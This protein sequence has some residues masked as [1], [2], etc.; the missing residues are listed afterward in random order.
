MDPIKESLEKYNS[1]HKILH[2]TIAVLV[3]GLLIL[4]S[5]LESFPKNM[6]E[7]AYTIHKSFGII[8]LILMVIR[9][10]WRAT[11]HT[12]HLPSVISPLEKGLAHLSYFL[13]YAL[14]I[15]M[16]ISGFVES[17]AAG[18][19]PSL[20]GLY[21]FPIWIAKNEEL[22]KLSAG[23]HY[24]LAWAI[25]GLLIIHVLATIKHHL[26]DKVNLLKRMT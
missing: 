23:I 4:G 7:T 25:L 26:F 22:A 15:A 14:L 12:P 16:P 21:T 13:W 24:W 17:Q 1:F 2:W 20:F 6:E 11:H 3:I 5:L 10:A 19:P 9:L 18:Y 8:V